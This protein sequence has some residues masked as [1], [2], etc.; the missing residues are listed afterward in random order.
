MS[1]KTQTKEQK[2]LREEGFNFAH[3]LRI[4]T[5]HHSGKVLVAASFSQKQGGTNTCVQ[6]VPFSKIQDPR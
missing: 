1:Q 3:S 2:T 5:V 4:H 6:L